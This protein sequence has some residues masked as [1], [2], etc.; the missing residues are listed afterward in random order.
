MEQSDAFR[1]PISYVRLERWIL[2]GCSSRAGA[3]RACGFISAQGF[4]NRLSLISSGRRNPSAR[5]VMAS[6]WRGDRRSIPASQF[7]TARSDRSHQTDG[8]YRLEADPS[9]SRRLYYRT[10]Q[11]TVEDESSRSVGATRRL[12]HRS[13][14]LRRD[15]ATRLGV[16]FTVRDGA[17]GVAGRGASVCL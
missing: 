16:G 15:S 7:C 10:Y 2:T 5:S 3:R 1:R 14:P 4:C 9:L 6:C 17:C 11:T 8:T 12:H 13:L